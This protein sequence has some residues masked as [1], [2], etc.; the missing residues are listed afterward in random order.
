MEFHFCESLAAGDPC[1]REIGIPRIQVQVAQLLQHLDNGPASLL[2][3][4]VIGLELLPD[5]GFC[6]CLIAAS[7]IKPFENLMEAVP[8]PGV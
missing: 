6:G 5:Q 7:K 1:Q 8:R 4:E 3:V 2:V